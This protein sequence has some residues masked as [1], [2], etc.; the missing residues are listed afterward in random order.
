M[1]I[2]PLLM[3]IAAS[4]T[5]PTYLTCVANQEGGPIAVEITANEAEQQA[6]VAL[7]ETGRVVTRRAMFSPSE[8]KIFDQESLWVI[9]RVDLSFKRIFTIGDHS[10]T[11]PGAC[12]IAPEP[13][14]RAF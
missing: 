3:A 13:A 11:S 7:P 5:V 10:S 12:K 4:P 14:K 9:N 1:P 2:L 6:I 8:V